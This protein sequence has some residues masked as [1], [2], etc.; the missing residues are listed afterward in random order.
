M[1]LICMGLSHKVNFKL[2]L[3][4]AN[5]S[6]VVFTDFCKHR[7]THNIVASLSHYDENYVMQS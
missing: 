4:S 5:S 7:Q 3:K 2:F 1:L 6:F